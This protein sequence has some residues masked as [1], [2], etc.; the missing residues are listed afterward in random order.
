MVLEAVLGPGA[1][2]V[3]V[4]VVSWSEIA[5]GEARVQAIKG[6][7]CALERRSDQKEGGIESCCLLYWLGVWKREEKHLVD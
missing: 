4:Q 5:W 6:S 1:R 3:E 7:C 2:G